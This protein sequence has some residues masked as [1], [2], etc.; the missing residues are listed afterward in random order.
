M[1]RP[2]SDIPGVLAAMASA[3]P[4]AVPRAVGASALAFKRTIV[5]ASPGR[6]RNV[7]RRGARLGVKYTVSGSGAR[8]KANVSGDGPWPLLDNPSVPHRIPRERS[9]RSRK[10]ARVLK[11]PNGFASYVE[12]PGTKGKRVFATARD[13]AVPDATDAAWRVFL[14]TVTKAFRG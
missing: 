14:A 3:C 10:R 5:A 8:A 12:H 2:V 13:A 11:L 6:M 1:D 7:G 4:D 9:R